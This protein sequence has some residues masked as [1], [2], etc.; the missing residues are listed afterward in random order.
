MLEEKI[1]IFEQNGPLLAGYIGFNTTR[2]LWEFVRSDPIK[3][4]LAA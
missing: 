1:N 3:D 2:E 4:V